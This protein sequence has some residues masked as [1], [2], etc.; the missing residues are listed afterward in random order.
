MLD[1]IA[2]VL[3]S[4]V[5]QCVLGILVGLGLRK[6]TAIKRS[7]AK[8]L[9]IASIVW[10]FL[11]SQYFFSYWLISP[12]E[13]AFPPVPVKSEK[14]QN[15]TAIWVLA[16]YHFDAPKLPVVSQFNHC[17]IERLVHAAN[18]YRVKNVPIY[19]TGSS[20]NIN[21]SLEHA[22]QAALFL[23]EL[24]V[25]Q[26]HIIVVNEGTNTAS[27]ATHIQAL[28]SAQAQTAALTPNANQ[29]TINTHVQVPMLA[30][31]S[32]ASHGLRLSRILEGHNIN[33]LF[34]PVH[35]ATKGDIVYKFNVP[36]IPALERSEKAFYEYAALIKRWLAA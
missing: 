28:I 1:S 3:I 14:W 17:S 30:V 10:G 29:P 6:F 4:P 36:A 9:V 26:H 25:A 5:N 11:C 31:V 34:V 15:A 2:H 12:L 23:Q 24:G 27:E 20:F 8:A 7:I 33:Y 21:T 13:N 32:S 19:L 35:Y 16:C 18:M 22:S